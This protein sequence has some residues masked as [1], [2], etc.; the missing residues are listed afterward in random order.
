MP[1][2]ISVTGQVGLVT[3]AGTPYGIGRSMVIQLAQAGAKAIYACDLNTS[4]FDALK[5]AVKETGSDCIIEGALL[6]VSSEE[7]T[8]ALLK[9]IVKTHGRFDFFFANAGFANYRNLNDI[10]SQN[11]ER[12]FSVM[13][14]SCFYA[15][16]HGSR[17]MV[18]TSEEKP[19]PSG[20]IVLTSSCAAFLGAYA[21]IA[22]TATKNAVNGLV[23]SGS[24]QLSS[25]NIRVNGIAPGFTRTSILT[26]SET[27]ENGS[28][29]NL[30][31]TTKEI[32]GN[33]EWFFERA[34][35]RENRQYYY[36]R[37]QEA[38]EIANI[39]VFLASEASASIN[40]QTI[41]ADSG[42]TA[43]ATKEA[44]TGPVPLVKPL[45]LD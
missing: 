26:S 36:N 16:K 27:A 37:L 8:V 41:L 9:K 20:N 15:I 12:A 1:L 39:G 3:G 17:A 34:G 14:S 6:D 28:E 45:E 18:V 38:E 32:Q 33:H 35:L 10:T 11:W 44:C 24:V 21:D 43:A 25:S 23:Q 40:G 13:G 31:Q 7:Q 22:Y 42:F 29:Y 5:Q 19:Q 30:K 2:N 4:H